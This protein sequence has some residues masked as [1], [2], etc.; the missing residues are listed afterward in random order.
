[1][2]ESFPFF[3]AGF[4]EKSKTEKAGPKKVPAS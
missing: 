2:Q 1:M 3:P 4:W